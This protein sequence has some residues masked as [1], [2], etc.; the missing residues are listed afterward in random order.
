[1]ITASTDEIE[2]IIRDDLDEISALVESFN[3]LLSR[4]DDVDT[5]DAMLENNEH[6]LEL[7]EGL[8]G[9]IASHSPFRCETDILAAATVAV[10]EVL[11]ALERS[12]QTLR[13]ACAA[14]A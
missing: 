14:S 1:M 3:E 4:L 9:K 13:A 11:S 10:R 5:R 12:T 6:I 7:I 8:P 2:A